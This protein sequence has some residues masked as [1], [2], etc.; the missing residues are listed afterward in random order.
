MVKNCTCKKKPNLSMR[1]DFEEWASWRYASAE[2]TIKETDKSYV[3]FFVG[4]NEDEFSHDVEEVF[5][6]IEDAVDYYSDM[7][8]Y[9]FRQHKKDVKK[10][11]DTFTEPTLEV[12]LFQLKAKKVITVNNRT[13]KV[14]VKDV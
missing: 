4:T 9:E 1:E 5:H 2:E 13:G 7:A 8:D 3:T 14:D 12:V 11:Q 6:S 10:G